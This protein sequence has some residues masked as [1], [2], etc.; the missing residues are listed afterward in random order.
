MKKYKKEIEKS[1]FKEDIKSKEGLL[2][3]IKDIVE[4]KKEGKKEK[5]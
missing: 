4:K 2:K 3:P 5:E 1:D